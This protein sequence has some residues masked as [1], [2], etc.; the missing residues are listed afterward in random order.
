M[1]MSIFITG[2]IWENFNVEREDCLHKLWYIDLMIY[3][4]AINIVFY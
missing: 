3:Y 2:K 1:S 4:A